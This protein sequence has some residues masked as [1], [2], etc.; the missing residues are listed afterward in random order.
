MKKLVIIA[1]L[2]LGLSYSAQSQAF[3]GAGGQLCM[4]AAGVEANGITIGGGIDIGCLILQSGTWGFFAQRDFGI[5]TASHTGLGVLHLPRDWKEHTS[6]I[7]GAGIDIRSAV[8]TPYGQEFEFDGQNPH[9][10]SFHAGQ[11]YGFRFRAGVSFKWHIYL[12]GTVAVGSFSQ[13]RDVYN[14]HTT[15]AGLHYDGF[16][17]SEEGRGYLMLG[18]NLGYR[19]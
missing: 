6:F 1:I 11:G 3:V 17:S 5:A 7:W 16:H 15:Q 10:Q 18:L 14:M 9:S 8:P 2:F 19:F 4:E 12:M 13:F